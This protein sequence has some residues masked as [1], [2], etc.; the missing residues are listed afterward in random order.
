MISTRKTTYLQSYKPKVLDM[1]KILTASL[2]TL[3]MVMTGCASKPEPMPVDVN[4]SEALQFA[5]SMEMRLINDAGD[6][7]VIYNKLVD[8]GNILPLE[9]PVRAGEVAKIQRSGAGTAE[10]V[11]GLA[12]KDPF[13]A[14]TGFLTAKR[15]Q[16]YVDGV[17]LFGS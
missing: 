16:P 13:I 12:I 8:G 17:V 15:P 2:I 7:Y 10:L 1:K 6:N 14:L 11:G 4:P 3:A 9:T 5:R